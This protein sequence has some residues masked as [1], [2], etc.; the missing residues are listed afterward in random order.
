V[1][2][3]TEFSPNY[4]AEHHS[5]GVFDKPGLDHQNVP[6]SVCQTDR[7]STIMMIP[8]KVRCP[9]SSWTIE[10]SG[11]ILA[12]HSG[13]H[14]SMFIVLVIPLRPYLVWRLMLMV[15]RFPTAWSNALQ[16]GIARHIKIIWFYCALSAQNMCRHVL[17]AKFH[18]RTK[19]MNEWMCFKKLVKSVCYQCLSFWIFS[20]M[21][22]ILKIMQ[23]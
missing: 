22:S 10:Y 16:L 20:H 6:R 12:E 18:L 3:V 11:Y 19:P 4:G 2:G 7:R 1:K 14:R 15:H 23:K 17:S 8:A 9:N 21:Q 13:H 5:D